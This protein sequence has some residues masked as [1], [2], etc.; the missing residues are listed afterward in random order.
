MVEDP[1]AK[2][3]VTASERKLFENLTPDRRMELVRRYSER[4]RWLSRSMAAAG[5]PDMIPMLESVAADLD[6]MASEIAAATAG[7]DVLAKAAGLIHAAEDIVEGG[8]E[9]VTLH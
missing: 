5:R 6:A 7:F 3:P 8:V 4:L 9:P 1:M 2:S